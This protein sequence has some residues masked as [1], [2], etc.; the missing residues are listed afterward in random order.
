MRLAREFCEGWHA[1]RSAGE[2]QPIETAPRDGTSIVVR[3]FI[4]RTL[5]G[6]CEHEYFEVAYYRKDWG[7]FMRQSS[8]DGEIGSGYLT[9]WLPLP[10]PPPARAID[11]AKREAV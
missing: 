5:H 10:E 9:H 7:R 2:W 3:G 4:G 6:P 1:A 8:G 11:L